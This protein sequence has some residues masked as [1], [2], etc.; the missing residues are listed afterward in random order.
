M[1]ASPQ[2]RENASPAPASPARAVTAFT[3]FAA[4]LLLG[5]AV[6]RLQQGVGPALWYPPAALGTAA[7]LTFGWRALPVLWVADL[8]VTL[9]VVRTPLL[10]PLLAASGTTIECAVAYLLLRR[11]GVTSAMVR[12]RDVPFAMLSAGCV[13][14]VV[15]ASAAIATALALGLPLAGADPVAFWFA[16]WL[17]DATS[18]IVVLP[19]LLLW[20]APRGE[21]EREHAPGRGAERAGLVIAVLALVGLAIVAPAL[22]SV[23][24]RLPWLG[25]GVAIVLWAAARFSRRTTATVATSLAV[26]ALLVV[27][28]EF[29][30]AELGER[31]L[32]AMLHAVQ[33]DITLLT[34][35]GLAL[36]SLMKRE[37]GARRALEELTAE[38]RHSARLRSI[39]SRAG[40]VGTFEV[41]ADGSATWSD[42]LYEL[43]GYAPG[44]FPPNISPRPYVHEPETDEML[45]RRWREHMVSGERLEIEVAFKSA[46]GRRVWCEIRAEPVVLDGRLVF[47]GTVADI[48]ERRAL[49]QRFLQSQKMEV[50]GRLAGG[51]AHDFNNVLTAILGFTELATMHVGEGSPAR[52][53][54]GQ[55]RQAAL[56]AASLTQ[57]LLAFSRMQ[58]QQVQAVEVDTLVRR[59]EPMLQRLLGELVVMRTVLDARGVAVMA[60]ATQLEQ[61]LMNLVV[62]ARDAMPLGGRLEITTHRVARANGV[63]EVLR[64]C[65]ND[66]GTGMD[67]ETRERIFEPFFTTKAPGQGTGLGL[68][69]VLGIVRQ[70]GGVITVESAQGRGTSFRVDLPVHAA[71]AAVAPEEAA[72]ADPGGNEALLVVEDDALVRD[73]V[74]ACLEQAGYRVQSAE[75]GMRALELLA[76]LDE[77]PA[78]LVTD[79]TMPGMSGIELA[80]RLRERHPGLPVLFMTGYVRTFDPDGEAADF[81]GQAL[82]KPFTR[83]ELL[84]RVRDALDP[85]GVR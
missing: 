22:G 53:N 4:Y 85:V 20:M 13:A 30:R 36:N 41:R 38:L 52:E 11:A 25:L 56:R 45:D 3:W 39:A 78:L 60:D 63:G 71:P 18:M 64:L 35:G 19:A 10:A 28:G 21:R 16:W 70:A 2:D 26:L 5:F 47:T 43:L 59:L 55:I 80:R 58:P 46:D 37:R 82:A 23:R 57:R 67:A 73:Y 51:V 62:N 1:N 6:Y 48:T 12:S 42:E 32:V 75:S 40:R 83:T 81:A 34:L 15:G 27:R 14:P 54:L 9:V 79:V 7:L 68:S 72:P 66:N 8:L 65:V 44:A 17:S 50:V 49:E 61:V 29:L 76:T 77:Q 69:T 33:L 24:L 31:E 84:Q 74:L